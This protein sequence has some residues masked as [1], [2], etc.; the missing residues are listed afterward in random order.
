MTKRTCNA[1]W[2]L[3]RVLF[4]MAGTMTLVSVLLAV[5]ISPW[6]LLLTTFVGLNQLAYVAFGACGASLILSRFAGRRSAIYPEVH[7]S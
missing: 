7:A 5:L 4:A 1:G 6:F 2:P 3:E